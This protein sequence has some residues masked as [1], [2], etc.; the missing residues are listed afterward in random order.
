MERISKQLALAVVGLAIWAGT[1]RAGSVYALHRGANDPTTEGFTYIDDF[2]PASTGP[3]FNDMGYNA[4]A[5]SSASS[6][7]QVA[8]EVAFTSAQ[9]SALAAQ[10]FTMSLFASVPN[11]TMN[12]INGNFYPTIDDVVDFGS[13]RRFDLAIGLNAN[14]NPVATL[15]SSYFGGTGGAGSFYTSGPS[16][17]LTGSGSTY[18]LYELVYNAATQTADLYIDGVDRISGYTGQTQFYDSGGTS[19]G[20][21]NGGQSNNNL[22]EL[23]VGV[24]VP[25]PSTF[26]LS[27]VAA[28]VVGTTY[29]RRRHRLLTSNQPA[30]EG[31][32]ASE[33]SGIQT[34]K[35]RRPAISN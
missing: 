6:T 33:S 17:T 24:A 29:T 11:G 10:G 30:G 28:V 34:P 23:Q 3:V 20:A 19:F 26:V 7:T 21:D 27:S 14:G 32:F 22:F 13:G 35:L 8:Y 15:V 5:I 25:E 4:W 9:N 18:H 2:G 16:Y 12:P 31:K 1:S